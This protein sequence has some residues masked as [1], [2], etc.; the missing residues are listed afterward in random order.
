MAD[1]TVLDKAWLKGFI[2]NQFEKFSGSLDRVIKSDPDADVDSIK[3]IAEGVPTNI[4][5]A[6]TKPLI[7]GAMAGDAKTNG[8]PLNTLVGEAAG[9]LDRVLTHHDLLLDTVLDALNET[10]EKLGKTQGDNLTLIS[11]SDFL[12][13]FEDVE[14]D[15]A[16]EGDDT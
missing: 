12:E 2:E 16:G 13:I 4:T 7:I 5:L 15:F 6:S 1:V 9:E 8:G 14:S 11:G 10:L 3:D